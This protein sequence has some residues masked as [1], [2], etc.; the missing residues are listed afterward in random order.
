MLTHRWMVWCIFKCGISKR[1]ESGGDIRTGKE[2]S[3]PVSDIRASIW[4]AGLHPPSGPGMNH[5]MDFAA[6]SFCPSS[7]IVFLCLQPGWVGT[8]SLPACRN[9]VLR[10]LGILSRCFPFFSPSWNNHPFFQQLSSCLSSASFGVPCAWNQV[11]PGDWQG[12][13]QHCDI[14]FPQFDFV[15]ICG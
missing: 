1:S 4:S 12:N 5:S 6:F 13:L 7:L 8:S 11:E 9:G 14:W 15:L 2:P 10:R 3:C